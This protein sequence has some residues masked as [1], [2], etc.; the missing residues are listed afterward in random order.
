MHH[1]VQDFSQTWMGRAFFEWNNMKLDKQRSA[2]SANDV[3][4]NGYVGANKRH[5][6]HLLVVSM[7][8]TI[9]QNNFV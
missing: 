7:D 2:V 1:E 6:N 3:L 4:S 8:E 9:Y 5:G